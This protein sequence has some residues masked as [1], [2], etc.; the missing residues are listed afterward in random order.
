MT[1]VSAIATSLQV[2][3]QHFCGMLMRKT[4]YSKE[5]LV[6]KATSARKKTN[7]LSEEQVKGL[8]DVKK[9]TSRID[10]VS[11]DYYPLACP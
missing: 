1:F 3:I 9:S 2:R 10:E 5:L 7:A 6:S 8:D 11:P 4:G